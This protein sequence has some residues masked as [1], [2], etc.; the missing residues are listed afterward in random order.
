VK[1]FEHCRITGIDATYNAGAAMDSKRACARAPRSRPVRRCHNCAFVSPETL[2]VRSVTSD[3]MDGR[4]FT[5][6]LC[7]GQDTLQIALSG[8]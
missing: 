7:A 6:R 5:L 2:F 3:P 8:R 1:E 4:L